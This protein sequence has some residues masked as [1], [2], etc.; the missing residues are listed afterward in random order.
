MSR[1]LVICSYSYQ[2]PL[3]YMSHVRQQQRRD[4]TPNSNV[5]PVNL[6]SFPNHERAKDHERTTSIRGRNA[7]KDEGE[8]D[9]DEKDKAT[10]PVLPPSGIPGIAYQMRVVSIAHQRSPSHFRRMPL[11]GS[12]S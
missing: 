3:T 1:V 12:R 4:R 6:V 5:V 8:Q 7:N 9:R 2:I 10:K 11:Q